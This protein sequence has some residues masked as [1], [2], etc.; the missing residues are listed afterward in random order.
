ME[1]PDSEIVE[2]LFGKRVKREFDRVAGES[3]VVAKKGS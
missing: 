2:R 1:C 3:E